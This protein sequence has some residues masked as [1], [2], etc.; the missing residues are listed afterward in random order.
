MQ[1]L[2]GE[3][4]LQEVAVDFVV[5]DHLPLGRLSGLAGAQH[6]LDVVIAERLADV[7]AQAQP[8]VVRLHDHIQENE[9]GLGMAV[10][11]RARF[12]TRVG[13]VQRNAP[14]LE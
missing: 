4:G 13:V 11:E 5:E 8:R 10:Q 7:S 3:F 12:A 9:C 6:D 1:F 14:V 2:G